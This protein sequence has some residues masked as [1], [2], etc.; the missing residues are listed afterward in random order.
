MHQPAAK[1][2]RSRPF[3]ELGLDSLTAV[4]LAEQL[5]TWL[6][7]PVSPTATWDHPTIE[8][9]AAHLSGSADHDTAPAPVAAA[10]LSPTAEPL[11]QL[12]E[13]ELARVLADELADLE[14]EQG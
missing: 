1:V 13:H 10:P 8:H 5:A 3:A 7:V 14:R 11:Q 4:E 2:L 6:G 9:L 12:N